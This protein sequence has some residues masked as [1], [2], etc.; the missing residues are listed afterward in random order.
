MPRTKHIDAMKDHD[1]L[2]RLD[3]RF[4][5]MALDIKDL[6]DGTAQRL[7]AAEL[8]IEENRQEIGKAQR[9][10]DNWETTV[11]VLRWSVGI[12]GT[13]VT[14]IIATLTGLLDL[15]RT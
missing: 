1:L 12:I 14:F 5:D 7:A 8:K 11:K 15:F 2:V 3:T 10:I 13:A 9:R 4:T 6:K